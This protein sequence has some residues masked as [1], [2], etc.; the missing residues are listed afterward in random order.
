MA[1]ARLS[2]ASEAEGLMPQLLVQ[3]KR[4]RSER[5]EQGHRV[6]AKFG[7]NR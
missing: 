7:I 5:T 1:H 6:E 4:W 2:L 3:T